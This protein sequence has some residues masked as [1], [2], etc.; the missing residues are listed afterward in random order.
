MKLCKAMNKYEYE[1]L[2]NRYDS[3]YKDVFQTL[4]NL[5]EENE[6]DGIIE[7]PKST[8]VLGANGFVRINT[9]ELN[10]DTQNNP[11]I[12][13]WGQNA[14]EITSEDAGSLRLSDIIYILKIVENIQYYR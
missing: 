14:F 10:Y 3:L 8:Q 2:K 13:I 4:V 12:S 1:T 7:L 5:I 11:Y 6:S 9:I